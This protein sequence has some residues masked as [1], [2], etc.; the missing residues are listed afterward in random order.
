MDKINSDEKPRTIKSAT[1][2]NMHISSMN[3]KPPEVICKH[4]S[5]LYRSIIFPFIWL[6]LGFILWAWHDSGTSSSGITLICRGHLFT[7]KQYLGGLEFS[8]WSHPAYSNTQIAPKREKYDPVIHEKY[9]YIKGFVFTPQAIEWIDRSLREK[10]I[11]I[12]HWLIFGVLL[13]LL[14]IYLVWR[15]HRHSRHQL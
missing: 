14:P 4:R 7:A 13:M 1:T 15:N 3:E 12:A 10:G 8:H 5:P 11:R 6:I 2:D 9:P